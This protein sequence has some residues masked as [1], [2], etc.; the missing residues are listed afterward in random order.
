MHGAHDGNENE[1]SRTSNQNK[2]KKKSDKCQREKQEKHKD[3]EELQGVKMGPNG[4]QDADKRIQQCEQQ[5]ERNK[6]VK[7]EL[8]PDDQTV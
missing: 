2:Q 5:A 8:G 7:S 1:P 6:T 4:V 3:L